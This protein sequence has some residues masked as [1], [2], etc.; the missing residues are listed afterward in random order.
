MVLNDCH[1][2]KRQRYKN[3][4]ISEHATDTFTI[5]WSPQEAS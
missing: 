3:V 1:Q 4:F 5:D 2:G